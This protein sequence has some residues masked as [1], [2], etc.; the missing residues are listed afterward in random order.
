[1]SFENATTGQKA[2]IR[3]EPGKTLIR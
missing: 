3:V 2:Q 1:V